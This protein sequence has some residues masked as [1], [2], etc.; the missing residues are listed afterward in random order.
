M[1]PPMPYRSSYRQLRI[2]AGRLWSGG[3]ATALVAAGVTVVATLGLRALLD[4]PALAS[5]ED[6]VTVGSD[7]I[8]ASIA[9]VV[10]AL[11]ATGLL[12]LL[13][14]GTPRARQF[15]TWITSLAVAGF[16]L[17]TFLSGI[18]LPNQIVTSVLYLLVGIAVIS[19][20]LGVART[21]M[22]YE[23]DADYRYHDYGEGYRDQGYTEQTLRLHPP[24]G[25]Y[26]S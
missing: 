2:D 20:L 6:D 15:F 11:A 19:L 12:H 25:H 14:Y 7:L 24:R 9:S 10:A 23:Q 16:I 1:G 3:A 18:G 17:Q 21:A 26:R 13:M 5:W 4:I 22:R 8:G